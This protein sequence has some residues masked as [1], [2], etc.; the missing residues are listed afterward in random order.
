LD[1]SGFT[2][3]IARFSGCNRDFLLELFQEIV[4]HWDHSP[5][6]RKQGEVAGIRDHGEFGVGDEL[7]GPNGMFRRTKS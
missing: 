6:F 2:G 5:W 3:M 4:D 7:E 1:L